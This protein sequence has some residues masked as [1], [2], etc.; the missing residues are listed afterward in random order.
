MSKAELIR[1]VNVVYDKLVD[2]ESKHIF[3]ERI[4]LLIGQHRI[5]FWDSVKGNKEWFDQGNV[6]RDQGGVFD[7]WCW[8]NGKICEGY[9]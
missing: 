6:F 3:D 5:L 2:E 9:S 4:N 7:I 1:K 8:K